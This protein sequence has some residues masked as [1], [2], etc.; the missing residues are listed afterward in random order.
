[1]GTVVVDPAGKLDG[2]QRLISSVGNYETGDA[3]VVVAPA[4][5]K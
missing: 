3:V 5:L 2:I 1:M 4:R